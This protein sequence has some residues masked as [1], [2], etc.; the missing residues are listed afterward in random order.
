M[1][2]CPTCGTIRDSAAAPCPRCAAP[3]PAKRRDAPALMAAGDSGAP[4]ALRIEVLPRLEYPSVPRESD[5]MMHV[6]VDVT[7]SG[8]ALLDSGAGPVAHVILALDLSASMNHPDK[9]PVLTEALTGMLYD[10]SKPG[11]AEVLLS[12]VLFA[13][14]AEILFRDVPASTLDPREVLSR[15][16]R[17]AL[18]FG[19]YTDIVGAL[20]NSRH[21]A[22]DQLQRQPSMP[23]RIYL[24]TDGKPQ[25]IEGGRA[26]TAKLAKLPVD[27]DGLAFGDDADVALLQD[28]VSGGRGGTVKHVRSETLADAFDRIAEVAQRVVTNQA[29]VEFEL[30]SGVVGSSACRYRPGRHTFGQNA[31]E[32]GS[33]F[34]TDLG[35]LEAGRTY[36][37]LFQIRVPESAAGSTEIGRFAVRVASQ[38]GPRVFETTI[39]VAR[40]AAQDLPAPDVN[41]SAARDVVAALSG[42]DPSTQL[43]ALRVRRK[44]YLAE[45]R[46]PN[47]IAVIDKAISALE[48]EGTLVRLSDAERA[49]LRAH[50]CTAGGARPASPRREFAAG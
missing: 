30:A 29:H 4:A 2:S 6:L 21:I 50:T 17:S 14:G 43:K 42:S 39:A 22:Q 7:P 8:P 18:R 11:S 25:D 47:V 9:Y 41:V 10:L 20:R 33:K 31:F 40:T 28:L 34:Q 38:N 13:Y 35:T 48:D 44:L 49:T 45:R 46:D 19:R 15:I 27:V 26:Q 16:D 37:L 36:S 24:L 23:T 32:G 5:P 12:V 3:A 1:P